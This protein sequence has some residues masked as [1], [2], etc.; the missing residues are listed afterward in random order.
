MTENEILDIR[1]SMALISASEAHVGELRLYNEELK[2]KGTCLTEKGIHDVLAARQNALGRQGR[3]QWSL[4]MTEK[5]LERASA[6][7]YSEKDTLPQVIADWYEVILDIQNRMSDFVADE[8]II[9]AVAEYYDHYCGGDADLL[10][11]RAADRIIMNFHLK[12]DL[13]YGSDTYVN[14]NDT[15]D[16]EAEKALKAQIRKTPRKTP[17]AV[18]G[19]LRKNIFA[20]HRP[21][22]DD[23]SDSCHELARQADESEAKAILALFRK[24]L[25]LYVGEGATSVSERTGRSIFSS[26][27]YTLRLA[28][29]KNLPVGQRYWQGQKRLLAMIEESEKIFLSII[30][31]QIHLPLDTFYGTLYR[32]IPEFF[33]RYD[34]QFAAHE[35]PVSASYPLAAEAEDLFGIQ[36]LH[37]YLRRL[38]SECEFVRRVPEAIRD[39]LAEEYGRKYDMDISTLPVSFF[40][41]LMGQAFCSALVLLMQGKS[42]SEIWGTAEC[43][44]DANNWFFPEEEY[45][46]AIRRLESTSG[47][48]RRETLAAMCREVCTLTDAGPEA[49]RYANAYAQQ[50]IDFFEGALENENARNMIL[51]PQSK[52]KVPEGAA[53]YIAY[54]ESMNDS[55]YTNLVEKLGSAGS[56]REQ[57]ELIRAHVHSRKDLLDILKEDFWMPGEKEAFLATFTSEERALLEMELGPEEPRPGEK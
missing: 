29:E 4:G 16:E 15:F 19:K 22:E 7:P 57:N 30:D 51:F 21:E 38:H 6:S 13:A 44:P 43:P 41:I 20:V 48:E 45:E 12:R 28:P 18:S 37:E 40:E 17:F 10:R 1:N 55:D 34:A 24:E 50:W 32:E 53:G 52:K 8:D 27:R 31:M 49:F 26:I 11:G 9:R 47:Q 2:A 54:G 56:V 42:A 33:R 3:L 46:R 35:T 23:A 14:I 25:E 39:S 5:I 36:Y